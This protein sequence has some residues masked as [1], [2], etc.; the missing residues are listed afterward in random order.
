MTSE[1]ER[2]TLQNLANYNTAWS[3]AEYTR[4]EGLRPL[5]EILIEECFPKAP[6]TVLDLGCGAGRTTV[7]M[8]HKGYR[9]T[10]ID[11]S[12]TLLNHARQRFP[13]LDFR[14]MDA[15]TL[16]FSDATFDAALFSYT[17]IDCIYRVAS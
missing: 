17:G 7:G 4:E 16:A 5:E 15:T 8:L 2:I 11:L 1:H 13:G 9:P 12:A 10:A 3:V 6:A 14:L